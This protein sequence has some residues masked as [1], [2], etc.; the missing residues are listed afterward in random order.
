M[1]ICAGITPFNFPVMVPMWMFPVAIACGN[2]FIL[3][4]SER[5]PS[6]TKLLAEIVLEA[7]IP[8]GVLNLVN[9]GKE[10]VDAILQHKDISGVSFVGSTPIAHYVYKE[11]AKYGKK[12]QA[13]GGAKNHMVVMPDA[14][15]EMVGDAIMGSVFGSA[16]ERCMAISVVVPVGKETGDKIKEIVKPKIENLKI[17]PGL[18]PESEMGPLVTSEHLRKVKKY[19]DQGVDE[20]ADLVV[21]GRNLK[22]QGYEKGFFIGGSFFD[23]VTTDMSIYKE[24]I[25]GPVL[26]MVRADT[27]D[28]ALD[29]VNKHEYG[30]GTAIFT[31]NGGVARKFANECQIGMV[32]INVPI[33]VPVAYHSFGGWKNSAFGGHG[34]YGMESVRFYTRLKTVTGRWPEGHHSGA[35]YTFPSNN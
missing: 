20:G 9:G 3:K 4:P 17:G 24:E 35:Q 12:V 7:G 13:M 31:S 32:G 10:T 16:G 26:S 21:D 33:P 15:M 5:D 18:D 6:S 11:A 8:P 30:N 25:F 1:G 28:Y 27:F 22:L 29:I 19:I 23:N 2:C 34:V 14:D